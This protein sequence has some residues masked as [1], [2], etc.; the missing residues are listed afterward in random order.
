MVPVEGKSDE[1]VVGVERKFL[2]VKWDGADG[3]PATVIKE[4]GEVDKGTKNRINDGKADPRGRLFA[5]TIFFFRIIHPIFYFTKNSTS[6]L[7]LI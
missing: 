4:I 6:L 5:G 2:V 7:L 1:F 3:S